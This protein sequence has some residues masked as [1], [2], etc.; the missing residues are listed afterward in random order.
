M[1]VCH[2]IGQY[3]STYIQRIF[4]TQNLSTTVP[5]LIALLRHDCGPRFAHPHTAGSDVKAIS[6]ITLSLTDIAHRNDAY[7]S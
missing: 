4:L 1:L 3:S 7:C 2:V 6:S 5:D